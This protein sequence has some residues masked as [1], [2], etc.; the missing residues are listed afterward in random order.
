M[1]EITRDGKLNVAL[2]D[3]PMY[4]KVKQ[5]LSSFS[6]FPFTKISSQPDLQAVH[7]LLLH[8][9]PAPARADHLQHQGLLRDEKASEVTLQIILNPLL[10][11][12]ELFSFTEFE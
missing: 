10:V 12:R 7:G 5:L 2:S 3:D 8:G 4:A 1:L 9:T 6:Q 11:N